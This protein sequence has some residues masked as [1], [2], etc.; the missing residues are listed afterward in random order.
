MDPGPG[1][2]SKLAHLPTAA[3]GP[4]AEGL[5]A[6]LAA[7]GWVVLPERL[8]I[9]LV[10]ALREGFLPLLERHVSERQPHEGGPNRGVE[11]YGVF[12]PFRP[13]FD[14]PRLVENPMVLDVLENV[15]GPDLE[16]SYFG[17]DTPFP[18]AE[19]QPVHQD[20]EPLFPEWNAHLPPYAVILNVCLVDVDRHRGPLEL[21]PG[22]GEPPPGADPVPFLGPAGTLLLRDIRLWH[23][24][25]PNRSDR[26]RPMLSLLYNRPWFRFGIGRPTMN[27]SHY[28]ALSQRG[29]TLLRNAWRPPAG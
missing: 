24:G 27:R 23:R 19:F 14:D 8:P 5:A 1:G 25:S 10:S 18:G 20:G 9:E 28:E 7:E 16:C 29:R 15:L 22:P 2:V 3:S 13:P 12:V 11:R 21:F 6:V 26:A 17:S 4:T